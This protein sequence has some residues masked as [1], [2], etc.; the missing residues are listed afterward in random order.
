[1]EY[2]VVESDFEPGV[3]KVEVH[4]H[5]SGDCYITNFYGPKSKE[6]AVEY[7]VFKIKTSAPSD[8]FHAVM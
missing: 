7:L 3:W 8:V 5:R 4:D 6:R 1:M 2:E